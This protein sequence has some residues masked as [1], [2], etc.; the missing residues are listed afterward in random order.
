[1]RALRSNLVHIKAFLT[2]FRVGQLKI[3]VSNVVRGNFSVFF[4]KQAKK[5]NFR[6][7]LEFFDQKTAIFDAH[8]PSQN[9]SFWRRSDFRTIL[10]L[11]SKKWMS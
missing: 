2:N 4:K 10:R 3:D 6:L 1:M 7:F 5:V 8:S 9:Y 11:V